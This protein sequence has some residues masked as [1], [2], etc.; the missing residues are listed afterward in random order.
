MS[1]EG[2]LA[3]PHLQGPRASPSLPWASLSLSS[4]ESSIWSWC[5]FETSKQVFSNILFLRPETVAR[6]RHLL[7][8]HGSGPLPGVARKTPETVPGSCLFS[9]R[10]SPAVREERA[11]FCYLSAFLTGCLSSLNIHRHPGMLGLSW[12]LGTQRGTPFCLGGACARCSGC[13]GPGG[14]VPAGVAA[15]PGEAAPKWPEG[16]CGRL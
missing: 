14:R 6:V 16:G 12:A 1:T 7:A 2:M 4:Q 3:H 5:R 11:C 13:A 15:L 9:D 8:A 10:L